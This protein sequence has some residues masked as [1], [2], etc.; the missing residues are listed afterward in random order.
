[1]NSLPPKS[2]RLVVKKVGE[3]HSLELLQASL[4]QISGHSRL[5][6]CPDAPLPPARMRGCYCCPEIRSWGREALFPLAQGVL[7]PGSPL[8][9]QRRSP[10][11]GS[12]PPA[13]PAPPRSR[14]TWHP[15]RGR[16]A[17]RVA[18]GARL[19]PGGRTV[20]SRG[21]RAAPAP[22]TARSPRSRC[23]PV[24]PSSQRTA[25]SLAHFHGQHRDSSFLSRGSLDIL[26][27]C[28]P[29]NCPNGVFPLGSIPRSKHSLAG[30]LS[31]Q[32]S[33]GPGSCRLGP[34]LSPAC[35]QFTAFHLV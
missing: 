32:G 13:G 9:N 14:L 10:I 25:S 33:C 31:H 11:P 29:R 34:E 4:R 28:F 22:P 19:R 27:V 16:R 26:H 20:R 3:I 1:M 7:Q 35:P 12:L 15:R 8:P 30:G 21:Q 17:P 6:F 2:P 5:L 23:A 18:V 24:P